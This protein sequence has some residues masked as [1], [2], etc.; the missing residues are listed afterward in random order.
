M[1]E[2]L[3]TP[4]APQENRK[5][6]PLSE[7]NQKIKTELTELYG[8]V[9]SVSLDKLDELMDEVSTFGEHLVQKYGK[10]VRKR[11]A[12]HAFTFSGFYEN[13]GVDIK[14]DF[15]GEDSVKAFVRRMVEKYG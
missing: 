8:K 14:E 9:G 5:V 1:P 10:D 11:E 2:S 15:P 4:P 3:Q 12:W 6:V 7:S 13:E